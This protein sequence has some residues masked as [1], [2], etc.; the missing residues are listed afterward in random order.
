MKYFGGLILLAY[1]AI[2]LMGYEPFTTAQ[3]GTAPALVGRGSSGPGFW[4]TNFGG[5]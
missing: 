3:R 4:R 2:A 5:K 1:V